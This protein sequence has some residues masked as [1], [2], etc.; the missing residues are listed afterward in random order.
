M[1]SEE[2]EAGKELRERQNCYESE[3]EEGE[4]A[5]DGGADARGSQCYKVLMV[6]YAVRRLLM[7]KERWWCH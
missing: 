3:E 6:E 4:R 7:G 2:A 5:A 1:G